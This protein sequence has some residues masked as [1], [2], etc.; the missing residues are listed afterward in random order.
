[1]EKVIDCKMRV[2]VFGGTSSPGCCN[3]ALQ[4]TARIRFQV[5]ESDTPKEETDTPL[6]NVYVD[7]VLKS[8]SSVRDTLTVSQEVTDLCK[9]V[10]FKLTK[11]ISNK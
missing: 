2:Y 9:V 6:R 10:R 11:S 8:V 7:D 1:M 4:R 5:T 3:Y